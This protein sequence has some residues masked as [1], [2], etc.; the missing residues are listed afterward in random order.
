MFSI[1]P[2]PASISPTINISIVFILLALIVATSFT[3]QQSKTSC[4]FQTTYTQNNTRSKRAAILRRCCKVSDANIVRLGIAINALSQFQQ[5]EQ[6]YA[7][8]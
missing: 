1:D 6:E 8:R 2:Q 3:L 7:M 4:G 5:P